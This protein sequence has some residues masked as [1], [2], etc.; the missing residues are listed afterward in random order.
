MEYYTVI[1]NNEVEFIWAEVEQSQKWSI[2]IIW[3][4]HAACGILVLRPRVELG[5]GQQKFRVL[6]TYAP[7][8]PW[9][10]IF[11]NARWETVQMV[12]FYED[13]IFLEEDI[14][15]WGSPLWLGELEA[16]KP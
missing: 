5:P 15:H 11:L 10:L 13:S 7:G 14:S 16:K 4:C 3:L 6:T 2:I 9:M 1:K 8:N 12:W